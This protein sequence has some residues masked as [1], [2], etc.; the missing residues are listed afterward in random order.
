MSDKVRV[1]IIGTSW[2]TE[3]MFLPSLGSHPAAEIAAICGRNRERGE[4]LADQHGIEAVFTDYEA[5]IKEAHVDAVVIA[6]PDDLHFPMTMAALEAGLH[7]L[8][9]KPLANNATQARQMYEKAEA[10]GVKHMVLYTWR[11]LPQ[12]QYL[13]HLVDSGFIGRCYHAN[14]RFLGGYGRSA[15]YAWRYDGQ[16]CNGMVGDLGSHMID[17]ARWFVGD[18]KK[19]TA[20]L[21]YY[22]A[23]ESHNE[24]PL[25]P[26][27]DAV[28]IMLQF[29]N[30]AQGTIQTSA[31]SHQ[32]DRGMK[33]EVELYGEAGSLEV[34]FPLFGAE[35]GPKIRGA[36]HD[37]EAFTVIEV[38]PAFYEGID[39]TNVVDVFVKQSVGSRL[40]IDSILE[41]RLPSPNFY[42]GLKAQEVIDA[43]LTSH[44]DEGWI[45][46]P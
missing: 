38:P 36:R 22:V 11:W 41:D 4:A 8:C 9:E 45:S 26:T 27:N 28:Y 44:Q 35:A 23:H 32:A 14:F 34:N 12:F 7:V 21:G 29:E 20:Q 25:V 15:E 16:R 40:F 5:L 17:F 39:L 33:I 31:V 37:D 1:G 18:I 6:T 13:K 24:Q 2:W 30:Q 3:F 10:A 42:D 43:A 46:L 19:V